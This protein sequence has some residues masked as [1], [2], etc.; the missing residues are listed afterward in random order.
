M[1]SPAPPRKQRRPRDEGTLTLFTAIVAIAL[2]AVVAFVLDA[3]AKLQAGQQARGL[4][5]EAARAG[6]DA[7]NTSASSGPLTVS[8]GQAI[9][10]AQ[11]YLSQAGHSGRVIVTGTTTVQVTVTVSSPAPLT[12]ILGIGSVSA[13]ETATATLTQGVTGPQ[14][15]P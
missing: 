15:Q 1:T 3:G 14:G 7:V 8:P 4:A 9:A 11:Q 5:E 2:L 13:T 10:A 12:A 6:A